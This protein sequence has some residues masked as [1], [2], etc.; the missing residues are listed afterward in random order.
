MPW[1]KALT[2]AA[3]LL[4]VGSAASSLA[5]SYVLYSALQLTEMPSRPALSA[6]AASLP[7]DSPSAIADRAPAPKKSRRAEHRGSHSH[8][9]SSRRPHDHGNSAPATPTPSESAA[10]Q[11]AHGQ[12]PFF[13]LSALGSPSHA[14]DELWSRAERLSTAGFDVVLSDNMLPAEAAT[15]LATELGPAARI[16]PVAGLGGIRI[17]RLGNGPL[18]RSAGLREGDILTALNGYPLLQPDSALE[19]YSSLSTQRTAVIEVRRGDRTVFLRLRAAPSPRQGPRRR[20]RACAGGRC[21]HPP[22]G[23]EAL[24]APA[25]PSAKAD[26]IRRPVA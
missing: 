5:V 8:R 1:N 9:P 7:G 25:A 3:M 20:R 15:Q 6:R 23:E 4:L 24:N 22:A 16:A 13:S 19:A 26:H 12:T 10:V 17:L 2:V 14:P 21:L 18:A 11:S